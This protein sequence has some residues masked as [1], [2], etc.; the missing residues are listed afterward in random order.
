MPDDDD[1]LCECIE[2]YCEDERI[3]WWKLILLG[4]FL[5]T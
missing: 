4:W 2:D 1:L 3:P 5:F